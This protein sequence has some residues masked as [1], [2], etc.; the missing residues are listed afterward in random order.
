MSKTIWKSYE[1][2]CNKS[3]EHIKSDVFFANG[4]CYTNLEQMSWLFNKS[5]DELSAIMETGFDSKEH[6]DLNCIGLNKDSNIIP[7]FNLN[8]LRYIDYKLSYLDSYRQFSDWAYSINYGLG[9]E[10]TAKQWILNLIILFAPFVALLGFITNQHKSIFHVAMCIAALCSPVLLLLIHDRFYLF[11]LTNILAGAGYA[12]GAGPYEL[13]V[14]LVCFTFL[15][16]GS[17]AERPWGIFNR[18][19]RKPIQY[20]YDAFRAHTWRSLKSL[21]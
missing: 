13:V 4:T 17:F 18:N 1:F 2:Y 16:Y 6:K 19:Y 12:L 20:G 14:F 21:E 8:V 10:K 9:T 7:Y 3:R 5:E 11:V 15:I